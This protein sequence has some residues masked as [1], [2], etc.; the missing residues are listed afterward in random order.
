M[1]KTPFCVFDLK[2][3]VPCTKCQA[4]IES[5]KY[6]M[7]DFEVSKTLYEIEKGF[8]FLKDAEYVRSLEVSGI[9]VIILRGIE[10]VYR[11]YIRHLEARIARALVY[12]RF[13]NIKVV[14]E[15]H[16]LRAMAEQ[17]LSPARL[18]SFTVVW[19]PDGSS[20]YVFRIRRSD[21]KRLPYPVNV[22]EK[23]IGSILQKPVKISSI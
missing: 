16:D 10:E 22:L 18:I 23:I 4:L 8:P 3:G 19:F 14:L 11:S 2:T 21:F 7:L 12:R 17:L 20:E 15:K 1:V 6:S 9:L 5:G 13:K